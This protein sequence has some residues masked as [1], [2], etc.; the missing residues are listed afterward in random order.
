VDKQGKVLSVIRKVSIDQK[1]ADMMNQ[2]TRVTGLHYE[3][4]EAKSEVR[5]EKQYRAELFAQIAELGGTI[6]KNAKTADMEA[7]I[8]ELQNKE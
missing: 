2:D 7:K 4:D 8:A 3:L 5:D 6:A 1:D